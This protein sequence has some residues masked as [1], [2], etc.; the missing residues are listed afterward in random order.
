LPSEEEDRIYEEI[1]AY[2]ESWIRKQ[3]IKTVWREAES[4]TRQWR[5]S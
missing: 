4:E 5:T 3:Q 2:Y 1:K